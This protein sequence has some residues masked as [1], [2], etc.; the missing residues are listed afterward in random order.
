MA[1]SVQTTLLLSALGTESMC[2]G[3]DCPYLF[4]H[5]PLNLTVRGLERKFSDPVKRMSQ[6]TQNI[7]LKL[8]Q[9]PANI[10]GNDWLMTNIIPLHSPTV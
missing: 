4:T 1:Q 5:S 3:L 2:H 6:I 10:L 8:L 7:L 9:Y